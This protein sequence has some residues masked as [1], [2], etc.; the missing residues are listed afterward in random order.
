MPRILLL[1]KAG[2]IIKEPSEIPMKIEH[3][4]PIAMIKDDKIELNPE[5][6]EKKKRKF[7]QK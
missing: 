1:D 7:Y 6:K 5:K 3:Q 2:K 4:E